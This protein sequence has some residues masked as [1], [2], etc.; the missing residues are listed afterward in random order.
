MHA[1]YVFFLC[2]FSACTRTS[3]GLVPTYCMQSEHR[4]AIANEREAILAARKT[5]YCIHSRDTPESEQS[6]LKNFAAARQGA[7]WD[8]T[9]RHPEGQEGPIIGVQLTAADGRVVDVKFSQ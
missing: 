1:I 8:V 5:W 2:L 4:G 7:N 3:V 9:T 6:W